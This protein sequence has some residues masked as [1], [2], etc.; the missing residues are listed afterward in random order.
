MNGERLTLVTLVSIFTDFGILVSIVLFRHVDSAYNQPKFCS[1]ATWSSDASTFA[2]THD[3]GAEPRS[4]F[5]DTNN[6]VY[7][8]ATSLNRINVWPIGKP[9]PT[10][11]INGSLSNV[12]AVF[13]TLYGDIFTGESNQ[14]SHTYLVQ[15]WSINATSSVRVMVLED[16]CFN[17][18][19]DIYDNIYCSM[20]NLHQVV[21]RLSTD[22]TIT[23]AIVAGN[24]TSGSTSNMLSSPRGIFVTHA[25]DLYV[26]DSDNN[27]VQLFLSGQQNAET[28]VGNDTIDLNC[29][30]GIV[31]DGN[32]Y[33]FIT[34]SGNNRVIRSGPN[35][36]QCVVGCGRTNGS[37]LNELSSPYGLN[38]DRDGNLFVAD[39]A[40]HRILKFSFLINS[41]GK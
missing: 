30:T 12:T 4:L 13:V 35:G 10:R 3:V 19:V 37:A 7:V 29:P 39:T 27:R 8:S 1:S 5:V 9:N 16:Q 21:R 11:M 33:L 23:T 32:G 25:L 41:C 34:D 15:K 20:E 18:F 22:G 26:A 14:F 31:L 36:Y 2:N 38:F 24:G 28:V 40:N 17:L 6:S